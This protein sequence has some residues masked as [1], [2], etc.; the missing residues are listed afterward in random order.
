MPL[1]GR[2]VPARD[3]RNMG[4]A[5]TE[6]YCNEYMGTLGARAAW[7]DH[8]AAIPASMFSARR[9]ADDCQPFQMGTQDVSRYAQQAG[10]LDL[11]FAGPVVRREE[12]RGNH[13]IEQVWHPPVEL[14]L[15][16][17]LQERALLPGRYS[18]RAILGAFPSGKLRSDGCRVVPCRVSSARWMTFSSSR[19]LP[20]HG[21]SITKGHEGNTKG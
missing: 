10:C 17:A 2:A 16:E 11:V 7:P 13:A 1:R 18:L 19:M 8:C 6:G 9:L 14:V 20:G 3:R 4:M 15:Q 12:R 21:Y 5:T